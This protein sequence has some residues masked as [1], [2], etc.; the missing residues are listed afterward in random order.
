MKWFRQLNLVL[1]IGVE[2]DVTMKLLSDIPQID[3]SN[4]QNYADYILKNYSDIFSRV[5]KIQG[6]DLTRKYFAG[7]DQTKPSD[8]L[9]GWNA[10]NNVKYGRVANIKDAR[11]ECAFA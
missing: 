8:V 6:I 7:W 2:L 11:L 4:M 10:Y 5:V 1:L 9:I 3:K